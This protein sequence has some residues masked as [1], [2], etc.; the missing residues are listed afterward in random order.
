VVRTA[1]TEYFGALNTA[2][3]HPERA[4]ALLE[5]RLTDTCGCRMVLDVLHELASDRHYLDYTYVVTDIKV[6]QIG[7]LGASATY[8]VRQ[9]AGHERSSDGAA[10]TTYPATT[11]QYSVHLVRRGASWLLDRSDIM[12]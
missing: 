8:V 5:P 10:V 12:K 3:R 4:D 7:E 9:S 1:I 2:L 11:T 6:Q